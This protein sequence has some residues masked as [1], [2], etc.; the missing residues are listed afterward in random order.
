MSIRFVSGHWRTSKDCANLRLCRCSRNVR[1]PYISDQHN[2]FL[3]SVTTYSHRL[4]SRDHLKEKHLG[5]SSVQ[6]SDNLTNSRIKPGL[7][8]IR[9]Q[10]SPEDRHELEVRICL[11]SRNMVR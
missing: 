7:Y 2:E 5:V 3:I 8:A 4:N 11:L 1:C 9:S 10:S 6:L